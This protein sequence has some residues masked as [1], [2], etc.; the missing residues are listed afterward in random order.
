[1][2]QICLRYI[3]DMSGICHK[4]IVD[5]SQICLLPRKSLDD[6]SI[7]KGQ[8]NISNVTSGTNN[9]TNKQQ[10]E[11][12]SNSEYLVR[13]P[14]QAA[15]RS[16]STTKAKINFIFLAWQDRDNRGLRE[17]LLNWFKV[18]SSLTNG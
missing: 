3:R 13:N 11:Y 5:M 7:F 4:Y 8:S 10:P 14:V 2:S 15:L 12:R 1:M 16:Y 6:L 17:L 9:Q 18:H